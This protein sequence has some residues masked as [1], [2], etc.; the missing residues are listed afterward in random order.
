VIC[1]NCGTEN[2]AGRKFCKECAARLVAVCPTCGASNAP[3]AKFCGECATPLG[4][5][6]APGAGTAGGAGRTAGD[7]A[8]H[9]TGGPG[10]T[11]DR[12]GGP[13]LVAPVAE[14]RLVSVLFADLVGFTTLSEGL[15]P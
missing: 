7:R 14:R 13:D 5:G 2:E 3:D 1:A 15:D 9:A 4:D 12:G 8:G 10:G 11:S 6:S